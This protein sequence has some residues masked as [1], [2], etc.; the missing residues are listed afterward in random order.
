MIAAAWPRRSRST[1]APGAAPATRPLDP[2]LDLSTLFRALGLGR[3]DVLR[4]IE[5]VG[6]GDRL[7]QAGLVRWVTAERALAAQPLA[8]DRLLGILRGDVT[9]ES[10]LAGFCD[11]WPA[12]IAGRLG[13][14]D[15][16]TWQRLERTARGLAQRGAQLLVRGPDALGKAQLAAAL[17]ASIGNGWALHVV[18]SSARDHL[19]RWC[20]I[21]VRRCSSRDRA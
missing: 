1:R 3:A 15:D 17:G 12:R 14:V 16:V 18:C 19:A 20:A 8:T 2:K 9:L 11:L 6:P 4:A 5:R 7:E 13:I 10:R 21:S